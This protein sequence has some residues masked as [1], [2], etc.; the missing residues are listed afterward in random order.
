MENIVEIL[1]YLESISVAAGVAGAFY[2]SFVPAAKGSL[3]SA[4]NCVAAGFGGL[5]TVSGV[6]GLFYLMQ[7]DFEVGLQ[8]AFLGIAFI[9]FF[10]TRQNLKNVRASLT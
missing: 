2:A 7:E 10:I 8:L 3:K 1:I 4:V 6:N 5:A 9:S